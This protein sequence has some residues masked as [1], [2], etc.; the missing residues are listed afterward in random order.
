MQCMRKK[1]LTTST[2]LLTKN[3]FDAAAADTVSDVSFI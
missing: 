1:D 3:I 2:P